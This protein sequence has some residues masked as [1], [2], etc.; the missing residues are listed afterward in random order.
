MAQ[1]GLVQNVVIRWRHFNCLQ[2][3]PPGCVIRIA[4][5]LWIVLLALSFSM[6]WCLHQP[7]SHQLSFT[8]I[9]YRQT[10]TRTHR[11]DQGHLGPIIICNKEKYFPPNRQ[12]LHWSDKFA[13]ISMRMK[14][15]NKKW[16]WRVHE[17]WWLFLHLPSAQRVAA[18]VSQSDL[19]PNNKSDYETSWLV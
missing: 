1:L 9:S 4:T 19:K 8:N 13:G 2:S 14:Y 17:G 11:S 12:V 10:D 16:Y 6:T 18:L 5:L 15:K 3:W 7:E